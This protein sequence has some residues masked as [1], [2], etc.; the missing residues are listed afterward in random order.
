MVLPLEDAFALRTF[1][2]ISTPVVIAGLPHET[3]SHTNGVSAYS[4][5]LTEAR[6]SRSR[7]RRKRRRGP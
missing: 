3:E 2:L 4:S 1:A 5:S 6:K 7:R